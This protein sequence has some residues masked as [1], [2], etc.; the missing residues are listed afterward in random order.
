MEIRPSADIRNKYAEIS[1]Y[2]KESKEPVF[3]TVNGKGDT[4]IMNIRTYDE[5]QSKILLLQKLNKAK[6]DIING[7]VYTE[8]EVFD[9]LQAKIKAKEAEFLK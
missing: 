2:C 5:Q 9:R 7:R 4:V 3:V 6:D 1:Q 8:K